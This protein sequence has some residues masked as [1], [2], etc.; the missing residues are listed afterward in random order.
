MALNLLVSLF[1]RLVAH[2]GRIS[3]TGQTDG[4]T[5]KPSTVTALQ[6]S[7]LAASY[8]SAMRVLNSTCVLLGN[9]VGNATILKQLTTSTV[10]TSL[11]SLFVHS[12]GF[13]RYSFLKVAY[14]SM[15]AHTVWRLKVTRT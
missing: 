8:F 14:C 12:S 4:H 1:G 2:S 9:T 7:K 10:C 13:D 6:F 5:N 3:G 11:D 15:V